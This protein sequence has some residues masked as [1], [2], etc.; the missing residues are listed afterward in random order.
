MLLICLSNMLGMIGFYVPFVF[1]IDLSLARQ[2]TMPQ[3]TFLLSIIGITNTFGE[4][5]FFAQHYFKRRF[6][7]N[8]I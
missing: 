8:V 6:N 5:I 1:L 7:L 3:A 2:S 4:F